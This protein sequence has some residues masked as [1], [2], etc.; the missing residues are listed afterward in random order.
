MVLLRRVMEEGMFEVGRDYAIKMF[1]D[2]DE[3]YSVWTVVEVEFPLIKLRNPYAKDRI[4]NT[5]SLNFISAELAS[6]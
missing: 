3:G 5:A 2:G 1:E 6:E 4:V